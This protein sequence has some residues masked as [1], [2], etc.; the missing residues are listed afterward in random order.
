MLCGF[1]ES[2]AFS[3]CVCMGESVSSILGSNEHALS[4]FGLLF[5]EKE[6]RSMMGL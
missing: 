3:W 5:I 1:L 4:F 2:S 6:G